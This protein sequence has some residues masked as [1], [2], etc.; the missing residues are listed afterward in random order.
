MLGVIHNTRES[1]GRV[2]GAAAIVEQKVSSRQQA[3]QQTGF[4]ADQLST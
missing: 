1:V 3:A 4:V 2:G